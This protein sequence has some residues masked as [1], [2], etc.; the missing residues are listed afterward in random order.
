MIERL[1]ALAIKGE[2]DEHVH[3]DQVGDRRITRIRECRKQRKQRNRAGTA[4]C[5]EM[6][7]LK[8]LNGEE[9]TSL[10]ATDEVYV[11]AY[12]ILYP[13]NPSLVADHRPSA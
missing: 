9:A 5:V 8:V 6:R 3:V 2:Y 12:R 1:S 11:V 10:G 7:G 4:V 13:A